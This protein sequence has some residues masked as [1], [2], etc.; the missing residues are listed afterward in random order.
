MASQGLRGVVLND[1][2]SLDVSTGYVDGDT[3]YSNP[4]SG[5]G[6]I[7][8]EFAW[9]TGYCIPTVSDNDPNTNPCPRTLGF[10]E[11]LPTDHQSVE[12]T[13]DFRRFT[14]SATLNF[15][16]GDWLSSRA[17]VGI[18]QS[19]DQ[20]GVLYP[21]DTRQNPVYFRSYR[22]N[23]TGSISV[24]RPNN[25][26]LTVDLSAT[27]TKALTN[28]IT[29]TTSA[30]AQYY[31]TEQEEL[32]NQGQNFASVLSRTINQTPVTA[33]RI[34]YSFIENKSAGFYVQEQL[35]FSDRLFLTGAVRWDDNSAFGNL[36]GGGSSWS[37]EAYPKVSGTWVVSEESFWNFDAINSL[38]LRGAWGK[39]GRQPNTFAGV[40]T[41]GVI[42]GTAGGS[43]LDPSSV[44]NPD[45]GPERGTELELGF[46]YALF[47]ERLA[48]EFTWFQQQNK[49]A[50]LAV[51]VP[52]SV[53]SGNSI[54][55][56]IGQIDTRGWE[57][58]LNTRIYQSENF[59]FDVAFQGAYTMNEIKDLGDFPGGR[60][61]DANGERGT[62]IRVGF[63]YPNESEDHY[64]LDADYDPNGYYQ[65]AWGRK[66]SG[67]CDQG[68]ILNNGTNFRGQDGVV[69]G[70][71]RVPC[72]DVGGYFILAGPA[73]H[74]YTWSVA[75]RVSLFNNM[76]QVSALLDGAYGAMKDDDNQ[77]WND[78]YNNSYDVRCSCYPP[79][80]VGNRLRTEFTQGFFEGDFWKL[81]EIGV[82]YTVPESLVQRIGAER[83][84]VG[85][86]AREVAILW[87]KQNT[88][89]VDAGGKSPNPRPHP[90]DPEVGRISSGGSGCRVSPPFT[91]AHVTINVTF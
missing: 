49:D 87:M 5:E 14:G 75:P 51:T 46:D 77:L 89:G 57:A 52:P 59:S 6:G 39:A 53:G 22:Q 60:I 2:F 54:Q 62:Q 88:L 81:R 42:P 64:V 67:F 28:S 55:K 32:T 41:F 45:V 50:L 35:S 91:S 16:T 19:W 61:R 34:A 27:A 76:F 20:N 24:E 40:N 9:G 71:A 10:Q 69:L 44:G 66:I 84:S 72:Q 21:I 56:N 83:A 12:A 85:F 36:R 48:G 82:Q 47:D 65:D 86:S 37:P 68:V 18:D 29:S 30:G 13:R 17:V 80:V 1:H 15:T 73:F 31:L 70:G 8:S 3:R 90:L 7:F 25:K 43:A 23:A 74:P 38:R 4:S 58:T 33:A 11:H 78:R 63:P 79:H 26:Q